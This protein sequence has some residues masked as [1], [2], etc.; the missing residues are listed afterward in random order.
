MEYE[1]DPSSTLYIYVAV[2]RDGMAQGQAPVRLER[3]SNLFRD[4]DALPCAAKQYLHQSSATLSSEDSSTSQ[5]NGP[6][7]K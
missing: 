1:T 5:A 2:L 7:A 3:T 6:H 4:T